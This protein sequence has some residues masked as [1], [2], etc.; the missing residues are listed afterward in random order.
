MLNKADAVAVLTRLERLYKDARIA[1]NFHNP[2]ELAVAVMLSAQTTDVGINKLTPRLFARYKTAQDYADAD[3]SELESYV[4]ASGFYHAKA[5]NLKA[6]GKMLTERFGGVVPRTMFELVQL[7]GIARKSAN[8]ILYNGFGVM[9]GIAVDT[10]VARLSQRLGL[11]QSDDPVRIELELM[12]QVPHDQWGPFPHLMQNLGRT[13]CLAR[14]PN[15]D[16]CVLRD[17][18]PSAGTH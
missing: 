11:S 7:P 2:L 18:C 13:V 14:K 15:H 6:T 3:M 1:L 12:K 17:I 10:H 5:R 8:V 9:E 16:I 4:H